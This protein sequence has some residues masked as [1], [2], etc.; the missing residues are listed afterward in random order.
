MA[1]DKDIIVAIELGS[2]AIQASRAE[3]TWM[4]HCRFWMS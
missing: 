4:A 2:S 1:T 3:K